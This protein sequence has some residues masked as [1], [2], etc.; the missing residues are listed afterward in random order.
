MDFQ[1]KI[2]NHLESIPCSTGVPFPKTVLQPLSDGLL[3]PASA[4]F[5]VAPGVTEESI[6]RCGHLRLGLGSLGRYETR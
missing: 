6:T 2:T 3:P 1:E 4:C 5:A